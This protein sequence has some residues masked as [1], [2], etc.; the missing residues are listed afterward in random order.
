M[1][2]DAITQAVE[3][4]TNTGKLLD[5]VS[6]RARPVDNTYTLIFRCLAEDD[7]GYRRPNWESVPDV[8]I[9]N[10]Q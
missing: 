1:E 5:P 2:K 10:R 4:C 9:E 6:T 8:V 7:P 3:Y